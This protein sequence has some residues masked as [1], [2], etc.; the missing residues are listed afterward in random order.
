[1][2]IEQDLSDFIKDGN[3][4]KKSQRKQVYKY[5]KSLQTESLNQASQ[6]KIQNQHTQI[7]QSNSNNIQKLSE[8]LQLSQEENLLLQNLYDQNE[9]YNQLKFEIKDS[10]QI[11]QESDDAFPKE[12]Q[13]SLLKNS[14]SLT[15]DNYDSSLNQSDSVAQSD[16]EKQIQFIE[17]KWSQQM[18]EELNVNSNL[19][20]NFKTNQNE[21]FELLKSQNYYLLKKQN[22]DQS[23]EVFE[24]KELNQNSVGV[25]HIE[26]AEQIKVEQKAIL[27]Q[28]VKLSSNLK[29]LVV[30]KIYYSYLSDQVNNL[31]LDDFR[32]WDKQLFQF[33]NQGLEKHFKSQEDKQ[34]YNCLKFFDLVE[35][36]MTQ[37]K[38]E[39][40]E[41]GTIF[42]QN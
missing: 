39:D 33:L 42:G 9:K 2:K 19:S 22:L 31:L 18:F 41:D 6:I 20:E 27:A 30:E 15:E 35:Q 23:K 28:N 10:N 24:G 8:R 5:L 16:I 38:P 17:D 37:E 21:I 1:M 32:F 11:K 4:I 25:N 29:I 12:G 7:E 40:R 3:F 14:Q 13:K 36:K 26:I 34:I